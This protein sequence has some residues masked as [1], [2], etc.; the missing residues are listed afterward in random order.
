M[1]NTTILAAS[2]L[3][4]LAQPV[5]ATAAAVADSATPK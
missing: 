4:A 1:T 5:P 2:A 3:T